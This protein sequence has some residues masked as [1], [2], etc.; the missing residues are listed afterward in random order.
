MTHIRDTTV[1]FHNSVSKDDYAINAN[2]S[3]TCIL[4]NLHIVDSREEV[5]TSRMYMNACAR[6]FLVGFQLSNMYKKQYIKKK[7]IG[8][9]IKQNI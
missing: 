1:C 3:H 4:C 6:I 7:N 2:H 5:S 8:Q 9:E